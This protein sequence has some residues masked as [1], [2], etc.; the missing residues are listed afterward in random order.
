MKP[1]KLRKCA[2]TECPKEFKP[3]KTTDKYC[4]P[5]C[6][7]AHGKPKPPKKV[8]DKR[9][10]EIPKYS[11]LRITFLSQPENQSCFIEGCYN[12]AE[13]IEHTKGRKGYADKW[14][15][16][17]GITLYLDVRFWKPCC[18]ECNLKLERDP[19]LSKKYQLSKIHGGHKL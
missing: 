5:Q 16:D 8:S 12:P 18:L 4:S 17:N 10:K 19:E 14:A 2:N 11:A 6:L 1:V 15:R 3:F 13:T 7:F 9:K